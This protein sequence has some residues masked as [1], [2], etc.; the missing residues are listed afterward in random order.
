MRFET[1]NEEAMSE[2]ETYF[3]IVNLV[4][5]DPESGG[6]VVK[7]ELVTKKWER[8]EGLVDSWSHLIETG[9]FYANILA[10]DVKAEGYITK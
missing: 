2:V 1:N 5:G 7:E 8:V 6:I 3:W 4:K 9:E 10:M